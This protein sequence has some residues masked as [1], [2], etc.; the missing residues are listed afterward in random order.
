MII[1]ALPVKVYNLLLS[2]Q[3]VQWIFPVLFEIKF[4]VSHASLKVVLITSE[5]CFSKFILN[6]QSNGIFLLK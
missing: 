1:L 6:T 4:P 2:N 5:G 3:Y